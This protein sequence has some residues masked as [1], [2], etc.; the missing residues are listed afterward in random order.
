METDAVGRYIPGGLQ[1]NVSPQDGE[2]VVLTIDQVI[3]Y[4]AERELARAVEETRSRRGAL[5]V[6]DPRTGEV[7]ALAVYP[8]FDPNHYWDYGRDVRRCVACVDQYEPG[9]TMK[10]SSPPPP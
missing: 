2:S 1:R 6:M 3:Q 7:L 8:T 5:L 10:I 4:I 9:S